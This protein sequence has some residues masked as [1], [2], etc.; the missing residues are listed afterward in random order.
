MREAMWIA[1]ALVGWGSWTVVEKM[2]LRNASPLMVQLI[3]AYVYSLTAPIAFLAMKWRSDPM[4]WTRG[5]IFWVTLGAIIATIANYAFL[6]AIENKPVHEVMSFTQ[7]YPILS[8]IL[9]W[10]VLGEAFTVTKVLGAIL[11]IA[12]C[13]IMNR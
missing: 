2:A 3:S 7:L 5:G 11:M 12:G 1:L 4:V 13:I 6:F 8:F 9:C 10:A